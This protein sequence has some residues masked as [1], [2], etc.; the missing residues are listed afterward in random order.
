[1]SEKINFKKYFI[2]KDGVKARVRYSRFRKGGRLLKGLNSKGEQNRDPREGVTIYEKDYRRNL[3]KIF[4]NAKNDSDS[5]TDYFEKTTVT[6]FEDD[7]YYPE[8]LE[9]AMRSKRNQEYF[10]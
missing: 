9:Q 6:V 7:C 4:K 1:M 3:F 2:E 5:M 10:A 8:V